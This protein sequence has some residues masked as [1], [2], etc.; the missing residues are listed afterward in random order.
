MKAVLKGTY[1]NDSGLWPCK[2]AGIATDH[3]RQ[4]VLG[5][6]GPPGG[7]KFAGGI[8]RFVSFW[9]A[10][11]KNASV[12]L[13]EIVDL[14]ELL[15]RNYSD[16]EALLVKVDDEFTP[17]LGRPTVPEVQVITEAATAWETRLAALQKTR[18]D[19][20][21]RLADFPA[22]AIYPTFEDKS[23]K[24]AKEFEAAFDKFRQ[25]AGIQ[26]PDDTDKPGLK[27][28]LGKVKDAVQD[29]VEKKAKAKAKTKD[30]QP[31]TKDEADDADD[32]DDKKPDTKVAAETQPDPDAQAKAKSAAVVAAVNGRLDAALEELRRVVRPEAIADDVRKVDLEFLNE[33]S[34]A[35]DLWK[36]LAPHEL[37]KRQSAIRKL[38]LYEL[39][40]TMYLLGDAE[41]SR[42]DQ[43]PEK[44]TFRDAIRAVG[45]NIE[46]ACAQI[47]EVKD[48]APKAFR[49]DDA[50][51]VSV[52]TCRRLAMRQRIHHM[53]RSL[54]TKAPTRDEEVA[55]HVAARAQGL[56]QVLKPRIPLTNMKGGAFEP[57]Y[58]PGAMLAVLRECR[59]AGTVLQDPKVAVLERE[60][61]IDLWKQWRLA[62][63]RYADGEYFRYWTQK[64]PAD[65]ESHGQDWKSYRRQMR[66]MQP[67]DTFIALG[68]I[69]KAVSDAL[70][71]DIVAMLPSASQQSFQR[72]RD[73]MANN[74]RKLQNNVYQSKCR[75]VRGNWCKLNEDAFEARNT[76][77]PIPRD[78]VFEDYLAFFYNVPE[79]FA[80]KYWADLT[81]EALRLII[82]WAGR[83][84]LA[85]FDE[86]RRRYSRFPLD[87]P[88]EG[89]QALAQREVSAARDLVAKLVL[90]AGARG[91]KT[92]R[93][94]EE[95][96]DP[97]RREI[98]RL[99]DQLADLRIDPKQWEWI[100]KLKAVLDGLPSANKVLKCGIWIT[101]AQ[102][103]DP[104]GYRWVH[105]RAFQGKAEVGKGNAA[106]GLDT[107][108]CDDFYPGEGI[109]LRFHR[110]PSDPDKGLPPNRTLVVEGPW[111]IVRLLHPG[112][113]NDPLYLRRQFVHAWSAMPTDERRETFDPETRDILVTIEDDQGVRRQLRLRLKFEKGR[114]L[115]ATDKW[116]T[117][118]GQ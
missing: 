10:R 59:D 118:S 33:V 60:K 67:F 72:A 82:A 88:R 90:T 26:P 27:G 35:D 68:D 69:G 80:D 64:V 66:A 97:G 30:K 92:R 84:G 44:G 43:V 101:A 39:R 114:G 77:V 13:S 117:R 7:K 41:R 62:C 91:L 38:R 51:A 57:R 75:L 105:V 87:V 29:K 61:L 47:G 37:L 24:I 85:A 15:L 86:L 58:H 109:E 34:L 14:K 55:Q 83:D 96:V 94:R 11:G 36:R 111:A 56:R 95:D 73:T 115:P 8:G 9:A 113:V 46:L 48:V 4:A 1:T 89:E 6:E 54:L 98:E 71:D 40:L 42:R 23:S 18:A 102:P 65:L 52:F 99:L 112:K 116:P 45:D 107:K 100:G 32:A 2:A 21:H 50:A 22:G 28:I 5:G 104:V 3:A 110:H 70:S 20:E 78:Q 106:P 103:R 76:L 93:D 16:A 49:S 19:V 79:Q 31:A 53:L 25:Q 81:H 17:K 108:L 63:G 74:L 12:A